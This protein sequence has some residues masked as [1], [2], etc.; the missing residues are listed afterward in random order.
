MYWDEYIIRG[1]DPCQRQCGECRAVVVP[2]KLGELRTTIVCVM[3]ITPLAITCML[4]FEQL[5]TF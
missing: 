4:L 1:T 5:Q 2:C 3:R